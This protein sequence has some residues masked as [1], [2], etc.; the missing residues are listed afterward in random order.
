[1]EFVD[2]TLLCIGCGCDF[3]FTAGEQFFFYTK[4]FK[5]DP[6]RCKICRAKSS[7]I[8]SKPRSETPAVC[9]ECG[10]QTFV[11]FKPTRGIPVL[12]RSCFQ[13]NQAMPTLSEIESV[14]AESVPMN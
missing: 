2:R 5:N 7:G 13:K 6:K 14:S 9:A 1:M 12:C 10:T 11:P 4:Q 8:A 3:V